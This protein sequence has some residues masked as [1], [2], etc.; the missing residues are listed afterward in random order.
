MASFKI[1]EF[2][3]MHGVSVRTLR[4]YD[5]LGLLIPAHVNRH[6]GYRYYGE[7]NRLTLQL[8]VFYKELGFALA[9]IKTLLQA[10]P[11]N[12]QQALR[13]QR[14][15]LAMK[16]QRLGKMVDFI[17]ELLSS[18]QHGAT[19]MS[20]QF[21]NATN[22]QAFE[23]DKAAHLAEAKQRWGQTQ[24]FQQSQQ[25]LA[26]YS[27]A[28]VQAINQQQQAIYQQLAALMPQG[29]ADPQVQQQVHAARMLIHDH[30]YD[31]GV[32]QFAA[33]GQMYVTDPKFTAHLNHYGA[34]FAEF[35][36]Q[37]IAHYAQQ[38]EAG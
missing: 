1:K 24:S 28:D 21:L 29:V 14:N 26:K 11:A 10:D 33:L 5:Q 22:Q 19:D 9:E 18:N 15:L 27:D 3:A 37:A 38:A 2:A 7:E 16:Q 32:A 31:C 13:F 4:H 17:D 23:Q 34:G 12:Q 30:W 6:N 36:S 25:R 8:I 20:E 35:L